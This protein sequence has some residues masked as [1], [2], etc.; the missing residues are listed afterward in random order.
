VKAPRRIWS[1]GWRL[2]IC[3]LLLLWI[4]HAI[5]LREGQMA[6]QRQGLDWAALALGRQFREAWYHGPRGLWHTLQVIDATAFFV[7]VLL[8]G[9]TILLGVLRWRMVLLV[10]GL[11]LPFGRAMAISMVAHFFNSFLLGSTGGDLLKAYY[12]ARETH[13]RKMEA[14]VT[15]FVDRLIGLLAMLLFACLMMPPNLELLFQHRRLAALSIL[16]VVMMLGCGLVAILAFW[17]GVS[18]GWPQARVWLRKLPR[19]DLLE[20]SLEACRRFGR[21]PG[22]LARALAVSML[23]NVVC[24]LQ[25]LALAWGLHLT[26]SPKALFVIV[27]MIICIS[28]LPITPSGLGLRENL[29]VLILAVPEIHIQATQALSLSLLAY[30]GFLFWSV[31]GGGVYLS[32]K[33]RQHLAEVTGPEAAVEGSD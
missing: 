31:V 30:A 27:P 26:I 20:R 2:G 3:G 19:G 1:V 21:E 18:R 8:M 9:L 17:G 23:I 5:F 25:L 4:C 13:H 29:Y 22:F 33:E 28:A 7:S 6:W 24:V 32:L 16:I 12:A 11:L 15:V 14:V 10:Q